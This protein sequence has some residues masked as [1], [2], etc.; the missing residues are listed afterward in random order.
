VLIERFAPVDEP[1]ELRVVS[2]AYP[3][4]YRGPNIRTI[5]AILC[6]WW[7]KGIVRKQTD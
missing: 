4:P 7:S 6:C 1:C 3:L 2:H 5:D